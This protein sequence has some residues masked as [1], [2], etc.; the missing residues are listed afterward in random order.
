MER[1]MVAAFGDSRLPVCPCRADG[2][3]R[4]GS[5]S[6]SSD[7]GRP[8]VGLGVTA[9]RSR[10]LMGDLGEQRRGATRSV[11]C[12]TGVVGDGFSSVGP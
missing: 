2:S 3:R 12:V 6:W 8:V 4:P 7:H 9:G 5:L 1:F 10:D 11:F